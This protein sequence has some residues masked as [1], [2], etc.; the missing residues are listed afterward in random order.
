MSNDIDKLIDKL[1]QQSAAAKHAAAKPL[2][3]ANAVASAWLLASVV[4]VAG[5]MF[6]IQP[7]RGGLLGEVTSSWRFALEWVFA[8]VALL[9]LA[10]GAFRS[11]VPGERSGVIYAG[12]AATL[13]WAASIASGYIE[14]LLEPS[15]AGKRDGCYRETFYYAVVLAAFSTLLLRRR[16]ALQPVKTALAASM[17]VA[18]LPAWLMQ[19]FCMY[20]VHHGV[21]HH[22]LPGLAAG[23]I[24]LPVVAVLIKPEKVG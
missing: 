18:V 4:A 10:L 11:A 2:L 19:L 1:A 23:I 14:P 8:A 3:P 21:T 16:Y 24:A 5:I 15:M 9:C 13:L 22:L 17:F 6:V 7:W 20:E 12:F